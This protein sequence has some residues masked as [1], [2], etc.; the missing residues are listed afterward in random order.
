MCAIFDP[1]DTDDP[2][3]V[4]IINEYGGLMKAKKMAEKKFLKN[5][6]VQ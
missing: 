2:A 6:N 5:Y 4:Q 3:T 1:S